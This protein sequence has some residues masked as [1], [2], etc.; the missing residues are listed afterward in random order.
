MASSS[1]QKPSEGI[2]MHHQDSAIHLGDG[3]TSPYPQQP[4]PEHHHLSTDSEPSP[5]NN[6]DEAGLTA[7]LA[8]I[9]RPSSPK[10]LKRQAGSL[11]PTQCGSHNTALGRVNHSV[12]AWRYIFNGVYPNSVSATFQ[13][14]RSEADL[15][16]G[17]WQ[18]G[19]VPHSGDLYGLRN[20]RVP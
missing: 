11:N 9:P 1:S 6:D 13:R 16:V 17:Y 3:S 20:D 7:A 14:Y 4:A 8:K 12:P 19:C 2:G 18:Q 15:D 5:P 10:M